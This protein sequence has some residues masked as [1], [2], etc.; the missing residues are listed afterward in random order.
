M[1]NVLFYALYLRF[2]WVLISFWAK[3]FDKWS[4][5]LL[6]GMG[7]SCCSLLWSRDR[8]MY[9]HMQAVFPSHVSQINEMPSKV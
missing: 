5:I 7:L 1:G 4:K 2:V 8:V 3:T 6:I 9:D